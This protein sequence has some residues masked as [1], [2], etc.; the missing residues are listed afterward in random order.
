[1]KLLGAIALQLFM[2]FLLSWGMLMAVH[3][4]YWLLAAA[5]ISY[6]IAVVRIGCLPAASPH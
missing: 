3:G 5:A 1:M 6:V 2:A 4:S